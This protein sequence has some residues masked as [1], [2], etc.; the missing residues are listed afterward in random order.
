MAEDRID[1]SEQVPAADLLE[2]RAPLDPPL[3]DAESWGVGYERVDPVDEA[4]QLEQRAPVPTVAA[5]YA[6]ELI[7]PWRS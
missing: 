2:Q 4:A 5:D 3:T 1:P 6:H 7:E